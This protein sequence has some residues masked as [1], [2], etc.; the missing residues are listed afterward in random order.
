MIRKTLR[1]MHYDQIDFFK[2][3]SMCIAQGFTVLSLLNLRITKMFDYFNSFDTEFTQ[4]LDS[5]RY[6]IEVCGHVHIHKVPPW[7][8]MH[9]VCL[10]PLPHHLHSWGDLWVCLFFQAVYSSRLQPPSASSQHPGGGWQPPPHSGRMQQM[11]QCM[12]IWK[13]SLQNK[14][15]NVY[16]GKANLYKIIT[17]R[18]VCHMLLSSCGKRLP[19]H[20]FLSSQNN[21]I[22]E[23]GQS[24]CVTHPNFSATSLALVSDTTRW[25]ARSSLFPHSIMSGFSQ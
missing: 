1:V 15:G 2:V 21:Y 20:T 18:I 3:C 5:S 8:S 17:Y 10:V 6:C 22:T 4:L 23:K 9:I 13:E 16:F 12:A 7:T 25:S 19:H 11:S 14:R 24:Y